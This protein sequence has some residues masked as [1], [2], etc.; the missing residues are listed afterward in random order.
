MQQDGELE[1]EAIF[2]FT[3]FSDVWAYS[4]KKRQ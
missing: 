4:R 2:E 1:E 3:L